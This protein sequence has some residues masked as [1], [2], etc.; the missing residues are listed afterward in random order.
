MDIVPEH[1]PDA[2][3]MRMTRGPRGQTH[4]HH[5]HQNLD[6][7]LAAP[8]TRHA[9]EVILPVLVAGFHIPRQYGFPDLRER[10]VGP[11]VFHALRNM[12]PMVHIARRMERCVRG[13]PSELHE[14]GEQALPGRQHAHQDQDIGCVTAFSWVS[15]RCLL[16]AVPLKT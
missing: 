3:S 9:I 1:L 10:T 13:V 4:P 2:R 5:R 12:E 14:S 6:E 11:G 7:A 15:I 8:I 16:P